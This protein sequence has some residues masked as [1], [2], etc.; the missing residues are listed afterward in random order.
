DHRGVVADEH[1]AE[2]RGGLDQA[3]RGVRRKSVARREDE[4]VER[5]V[6][7]HLAVLDQHAAVAGVAVRDAGLAVVLTRLA[8]DD[9]RRD[10][11][12][13]ATGCRSASGASSIP[14]ASRERRIAAAIAGAFGASPWTQ[15]LRTSSSRSVPSVVR[16]LRSRM[17]RTAF[18]PICSGSRTFFARSMTIFPAAS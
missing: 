4:E 14:A 10:R 3:F 1:R 18:S 7:D 2:P 9:G 11:A 15:M 17:R 6:E 8:G 16:T 5:E 12:H 13:G